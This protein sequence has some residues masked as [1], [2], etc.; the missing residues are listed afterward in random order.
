MYKRQANNY[1]NSLNDLQ[2]FGEARSLLRRTIPV[3]RRVL[4]D[5]NDVTLSMRWNY[6]RAL[7]MDPAATLA[8]LREAVATF[9][10]AERIARRVLGGSHPITEGIDDEL[11]EARAALRASETQSP[12]SA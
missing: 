11:R 3:A 12:A 5:C 7:Y 2:R 8:D 9:E 10:D 4:G 1:A 6:A